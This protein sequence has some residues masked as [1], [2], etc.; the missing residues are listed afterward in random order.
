MAIDQGLEIIPVV[1]KIDLPHAEP[2]KVAREIIDLLGI[3]KEE[4]IFASSKTGEGVDQILD[5]VVKKVPSP[6]GNP[7]NHTRALIFDSFF[8]SYRG[9]IC[10]VR[11]VDGKISKRDKMEMMASKT[12]AEAVEVGFLKPTLTPQ[13]SLGYRV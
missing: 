4:I 6:K 1:N 13:N 5:A 12:E 11:V 2:E 8:D 7:E 3:K 9:V 10:Y